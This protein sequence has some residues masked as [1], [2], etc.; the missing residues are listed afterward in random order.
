[1]SLWS[2]LFC[3]LWF[4]GN[5]IIYMHYEKM[6]SEILKMKVTPEN[7]EV[8]GRKESAN[9][10]LFWIFFALWQ[11]LFYFIFQLV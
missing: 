7:Q 10:K 1:M 9:F 5:I 11:L 6:R 8:I 2:L 4:F 3:F